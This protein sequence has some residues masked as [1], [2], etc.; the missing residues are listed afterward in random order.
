MD[1][2]GLAVNKQ[3]KSSAIF[4]HVAQTVGVNLFEQILPFNSW[5]GL[6]LSPNVH[7]KDSSADADVLSSRLP[8]SEHRIAIVLLIYLPLK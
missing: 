5:Q 4:P 7:V 8:T 1:D 2:H 3:M 6:P